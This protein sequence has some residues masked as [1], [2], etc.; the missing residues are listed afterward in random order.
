MAELVQRESSLTTDLLLAEAT[1]AAV[2]Q[3]QSFAVWKLPGLPAIYFAS[4]AE[5]SF[6]HDVNLEETTPGFLFAPFDT[7]G[8]KVFLPADELFILDNGN[9]SAV[10]GSFGEKLSLANRVP[11]P[12]PAPTCY[13]RP[14]AEATYATPESFADLVRQCKEAVIRGE[15][16]KLVPSRSREI[17]L[18]PSF[19]LAKVFLALGQKY[20]S[21]MVSVFSSPET[22][23]WIG[24]TP[25]ILVSVDSLQRF[26]TVA[27]AGTQP[28]LPGTDLKT[29]T[30]TQKEI[31]E[32]ALVERYI[33]GCFKKIRL[34]EF[35]EHGPRTV[36]A[37]NVVHLKTEFE[38]DMVA[39]RY[40]QLGSVML[41]LLH[42]TSAVCGMPMEPSLAFLK[43][44]EKYP[45]EYYSGY[46]GPVKISE[47]THLFV[48]LRCMQLGESKGRL[49]AGGG[50]LGDSDPENEWQETE[51]KMNTLLSVIRD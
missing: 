3:G 35:D 12:Y 18:S 9:L 20:P 24:A 32:Q 4:S 14:F 2:R 30:W 19:D 36:V 50:V 46:L 22:G 6:V 27:V 43:A 40:P 23:T 49:Y 42:P 16:E 1:K 28:Y 25:E 51:L 21:A 48:N 31:E 44:R 29:V 33:I 13:V 5:P 38:V 45:R 34:R 17:N 7:K 11:E 10:K 39:T 47:E 8:K 26:R 41:Q 37:G 15:F